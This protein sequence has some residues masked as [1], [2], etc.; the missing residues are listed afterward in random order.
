MVEKGDIA[1]A[2]TNLTTT[3]VGHC[4]PREYLWHLD[5][6]CGIELKCARVHH[7]EETCHPVCTSVT[8]FTI[9]CTMQKNK[10]ARNKSGLGYSDSAFFHMIC[11][12]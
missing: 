9:L 10:Q 12:Q 8:F 3:N 2:N 7:S 1:N 5:T 4:C 11:L 6:V